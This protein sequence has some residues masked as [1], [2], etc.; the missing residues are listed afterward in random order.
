MDQSYSPSTSKYIPNTSPRHINC[1]QNSRQNLHRPLVETITVTN[2]TISFQV[3]LRTE[4]IAEIILEAKKT[5]H[6]STMRSWSGVE[7][8]VRRPTSIKTIGNR[9]MVHE[10]N[11]R[12]CSAAPFCAQIQCP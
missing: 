3:T 6:T 5:S 2:L 12:R 11:R 9:P 1:L 8:N 7:G 4:W 10:T